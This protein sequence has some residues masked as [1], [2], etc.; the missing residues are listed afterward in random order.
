[1]IIDAAMA[2]GVEAVMRV[3]VAHAAAQVQKACIDALPGSQGWLLQIDPLLRVYAN[4][5]AWAGALALL[6]TRAA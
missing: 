4:E 2:E 6:R 1:M 5:A 3:D